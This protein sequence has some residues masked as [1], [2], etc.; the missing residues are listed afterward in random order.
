MFK[1]RPVLSKASW[2]AFEH[3]GSKILISSF[4]KIKFYMEQVYLHVKSPILAL[5]QAS[6]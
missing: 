6:K 3:G 2:T 5:R 4:A 1:I